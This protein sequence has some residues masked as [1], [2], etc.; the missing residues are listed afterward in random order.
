MKRVLWCV[1][2]LLACLTTVLAGDDT[3]ARFLSVSG[4]VEIC[5]ATASRAWVAGTGNGVLNV[6]DHVRT[7]KNSSAIIGFST[8]STF[9]LKPESEIVIDHLSPG[10]TRVQLV[11]GHIWANVKRMA[12]DGALAISM[13]SAVAN[14]TGTNITC[15]SSRNGGVETDTITTLRGEADVT[16][17][18]T[19]EHYAVTEGQQIV[20]RGAQVQQQNVDVSG[21]GLQWNQELRNMGSSVDFGDIPGILRN[22]RENEGSLIRNLRSSIG[23]ANRE[24][25]PALLKAV[26]RAIGV[27]DEDA[28]TMNNFMRRVREAIGRVDQGLVS[29]IADCLRSNASFRTDVGAMLRQLRQIESLELG[30][31]PGRIESMRSSLANGMTA[32]REANAAI[33]EGTAA[34][35]PVLIELRQRVA[36]FQQTLAGAE[37][38][39]ARIQR[40]LSDMIN[41]GQG[42]IQQARAMAR[43]TASLA[44]AI[45]GY[46]QELR[47]ISGRT[48]TSAS[49]NI[50]AEQ[51]A[52]QELNDRLNAMAER[53]TSLAGEVGPI[54]EAFDTARNA[55]AN[56]GQPQDAYKEARDT[57]SSVVQGDLADAANGL[58]ALRSELQSLTEQK[59]QLIDRMSEK[60][61]ASLVLRNLA[62][63]LNRRLSD[64]ASMLTTISTSLSR[65][66]TEQTTLLKS[67]EVTIIDP[68]VIT[69][70]MDSE[71]NLSSLGSELQ[72]QLSVFYRDLDGLGDEARLRLSIQVYRNY[73]RVRRLYQTTQRLYESTQ[74]AA[75]RGIATMELEEV[76]AIWERASDE[77]QRFGGDLETRL[78]DLESQLGRFPPQ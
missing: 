17:R 34:N 13:D 32:I 29:A 52:V 40:Q 46:R 21:Q 7:A 63:D 5:H 41:A 49:T 51:A 48:G 54:Q 15:G 53:I 57:L 72:N 58:E 1:F 8:F 75:G 6:G 68:S 69:Q 12:A 27:L 78:N 26:D 3:G 33:P 76:Q 43:Q 67:L 24:S 30:E 59:T 18:N 61:A 73:S 22:I 77:F 20:V 2:L 36:E 11:D 56:P 25:A 39:I 50:E 31:I 9:V 71:E 10:N 70:M 42:N 38:E 65:F 14:I 74:R 37:S 44:D 66:T 4:T 28:M 23:G 62:N 16:V 55:V 47:R 35:A 19:G 60:L 45:A 64:L